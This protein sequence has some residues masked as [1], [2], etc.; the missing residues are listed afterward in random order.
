MRHITAVKEY[1]NELAHWDIDAPETK[2]AALTETKQLL[3]LLK[4]IDHDPRPWPAEAP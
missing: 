1:L 4:L 3:S 2:A